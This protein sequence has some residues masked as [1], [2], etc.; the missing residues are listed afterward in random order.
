MA[1]LGDP[2]SF[3]ITAD[4]SRDPLNWYART[5]TLG[6]QSINTFA[7][8]SFPAHLFLKSNLYGQHV[9]DGITVGKPT[10]I[11]FFINRAINNETLTVYEP[12]TQARNFMHVMDVAKAYVQSAERFLK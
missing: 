1:V 3:P 4:Q 7:D 11:N 9:V 12:G 10:V 5:K 6:E 2:E 8:G